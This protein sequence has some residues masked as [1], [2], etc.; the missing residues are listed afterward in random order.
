[1]DM[2]ARETTVPNVHLLTTGTAN[3]SIIHLLH[4]TRLPELIRRLRQQYDL[5][6]IDA[7]PVLQMADARVLG[8]LADGVAFVIRSG[9]T[10]RDMAIDA[11]RRF[12]QD[13]TLVLGTILNMWDPRDS[14]QKRHY[15]SDAYYEHYAHKETT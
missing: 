7:P 8:R 1:L 12:Q 11:C 6:L 13:G 5:I 3:R 14:M 10:T 2:L 9:R 15:Y 4:S